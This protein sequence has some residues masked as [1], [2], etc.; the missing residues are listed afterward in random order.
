MH[1]KGREG[2]IPNSFKQQHKVLLS[3]DL[4]AVQTYV[5]ITERKCMY[6]VHFCEGY[7]ACTTTLTKVVLV[8]HVQEKESPI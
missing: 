6:N 7:Y 3:W 4:G 5:D 2:P 1:E 8:A